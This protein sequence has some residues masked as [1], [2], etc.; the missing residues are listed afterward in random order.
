LLYR[1]ENNIAYQI[2]DL[3]HGYY[4]E[5]REVMLGWFDNRENID[6]YSIAIHIPGILK[7]G[8]Y[9]IHSSVNYFGKASS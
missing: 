4:P 5:D 2:F 7:W 1:A 6:F 3:P 9:H 8:D